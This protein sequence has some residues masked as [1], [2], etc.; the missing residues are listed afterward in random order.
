MHSL[1]V[2]PILLA[3]KVS[4]NHPGSRRAGRN[5]VHLEETAKLVAREVRY[6]SLLTVSRAAA[7]AISSGI[8]C[9][10]IFLLDTRQWGVVPNRVC[11]PYLL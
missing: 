3:V 6:I 5:S 10:N 11:V 2:H 4:D 8:R 1:V 7:Y 9:N